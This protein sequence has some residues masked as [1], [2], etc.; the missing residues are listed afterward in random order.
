MCKSIVLSFIGWSPISCLSSANGGV[1][2]DDC[3]CGGMDRRSEKE[4]V[5]PYRRVRSTDRVY[6]VARDE[7]PAAEM[8][9]CCPRSISFGVCGVTHATQYS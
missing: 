5:N 6:S 2:W 9:W 3:P 7:V 8:I 1:K 4:A